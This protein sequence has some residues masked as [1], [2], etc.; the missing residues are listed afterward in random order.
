M[1]M[2][3][4]GEKPSQQRPVSDTV[5]KK[6]TGYQIYSYLRTDN[7]SLED[8][9]HEKPQ[10][11]HLCELVR[12]RETLPMLLCQSRKQIYLFFHPG[13]GDILG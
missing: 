8:S 11:R 4:V 5:G 6:N 3:V 1:E 10:L 7:H 2:V 13:L 9:G 12:I